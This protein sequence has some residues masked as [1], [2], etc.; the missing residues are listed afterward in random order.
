[1]THPQ[2]LTDGGNKYNEV[3]ALL[4]EERER[5][6]AAEPGQ[7]RRTNPNPNVRKSGAVGKAVLVSMVVFEEGS[8]TAA[9]GGSRER[10]GFNCARRTIFVRG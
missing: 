10:R 2:E 6:N 7:M 9:R 4:S 3:A 1:M 8:I 5:R